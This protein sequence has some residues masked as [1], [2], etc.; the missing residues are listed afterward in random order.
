M[1]KGSSNKENMSIMNRL[2]YIHIT[3]LLTFLK[4]KITINSIIVGK[5]LN[6]LINF[7]CNLYPRICLLILVREEVG[8]EKH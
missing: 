4:T 3:S 8:K 7:F 2:L 5:F 6:I 1:T